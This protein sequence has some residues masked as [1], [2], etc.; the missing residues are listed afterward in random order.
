MLEQLGG[1]E[2]LFDVNTCSF[3]ASLSSL[4]RGQLKNW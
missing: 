4:R 2:I 1:H 3:N